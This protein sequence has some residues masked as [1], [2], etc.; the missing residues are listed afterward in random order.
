V[1]F[2]AALVDHAAFVRG[3]TATDFLARHGEALVADPEP[4][5]ADL[6]GAALFEALVGAAARGAAGG[7][8]RADA[9]PW[10]RAPGFRCGS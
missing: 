2:L 7:A 3:E 6:A 8:P 1:G 10:D 5:D 4:R 9:D